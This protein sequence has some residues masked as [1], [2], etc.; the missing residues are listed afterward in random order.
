MLEL[1]LVFVFVLKVLGYVLPVAAVVFAYHVYQG[2]KKPLFF[3]R[4]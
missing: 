2:Y 4:S 1:A 3:R